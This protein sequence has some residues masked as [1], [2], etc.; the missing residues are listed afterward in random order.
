[1]PDKRPGPMRCY[2]RTPIMAN[3]PIPGPTWPAVDTTSVRTVPPAEPKETV[4]DHGR[5][6]PPA[7]IPPTSPNTGEPL[8]R[9]CTRRLSST[10]VIRPPAVTGELIRVPYA[11]PVSDSVESSEP[12]TSHGR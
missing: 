11:G 10:P 7:G 4:A 2:T 12:T 8:A 6:A 5:F 9:T 1:M 3:R